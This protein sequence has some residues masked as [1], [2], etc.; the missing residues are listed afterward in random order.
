MP[1]WSRFRTESTFLGHTTHNREVREKEQKEQVKVHI[2]SI[3]DDGDV[4]KTKERTEE[5]KAC[6]EQCNI[7]HQL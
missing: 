3:T 6:T 1:R 4:T 7:P 2:T 5:Y